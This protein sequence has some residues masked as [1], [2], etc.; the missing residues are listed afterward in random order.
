MTIEHKDIPEDGLHEPKGV[1][2]ANSGQVYVANGA[3]SGNWTDAFQLANLGIERLIDGSSAATS[4]EPTGLGDANAIQIEFG[5]AEGTALDPVNLLADGTLQI[6]ETGLYRIK[7]ALQF[8]RTGGAGTSLLMFRVLGDG[9]QL[10]RSVGSRL[11]SAEVDLYFEND[12]W[13]TLPA[14]TELTFEIIRD[15]AGNNSG[16]LFAIA[17]SGS[18]NDVPC[19]SLRVERWSA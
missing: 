15:A 8:G 7:I 11:D 4:Q 17:A 2:V 19:A 10:G 13:V 3:G 14:G 1:S 6:N 5:A 18:W 9:V 16:G 12:T